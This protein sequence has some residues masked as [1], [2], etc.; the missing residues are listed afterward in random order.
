MILTQLFVEGQL[1][2]V[3]AYFYG[4]ELEIANKLPDPKSFVVLSKRWIGQHAF[5]WMSKHHRLSEDYE[6]QPQS[7]EAML[8]WAMIAHTLRRLTRPP[9]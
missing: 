6:F 1:Q 4:W 8:G 3:D 5:A 2:D 7:S 9:T